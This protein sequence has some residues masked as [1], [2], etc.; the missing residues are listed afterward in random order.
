MSKRFA[1]YHGDCEDVMKKFPDN[2][3]H[4]IVTDPRYGLRFMGKQWDYDVPNIN[5]WGE[6]LRVLRPGGHLLA[7]AGTRTYHRMA[8]NI[9]DAGFEIRDMIG[10]IYGSGM[11][12]S[13]N[14]GKAID[15][16]AGAEREVIGTQL[17]KGNAALSC[18]EKGGTYGVQVGVGVPKEI[19][20]T[21]PATEAAKQWD[22]WGTGLKPAHEPICLARKPLD[23]MVAANVIEHGTGALNIEA[24]RVGTDKV[25]IKHNEGDSSK[26]KYIG[27]SIVHGRWPANLVH[28]GSPE[29]LAVFPQSATG[30]HKPYQQKNRDSYSGSM[31]EQRLYCNDASDGSAARFFYTAKA[32]Q[33]DRGEGNKHP[34]V[35]PVDLMRYLCRLVTPPKGIVLDP[36][37]G[38]GSTGK[39]AVLEGFRFIGIELDESDCRTA[40][41][42][43]EQA[44]VLWKAPKLTTL[45]FGK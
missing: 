9:E 24:C 39:A 12:K 37:M 5:K 26:P 18:K 25:I 22:G 38:S 40:I 1:I 13:R 42:R 4:A 14:V 23:G 27:Q 33:K 41:Q 8:V 36:F 2:Y 16:D 34:T 45:G 17:L 35:K 20:I 43:L 28:D 21:A 32:N 29:V 44:V 3:V 30:S 15:K 11:P 19:N 10:W 7:F 6:C 31:P